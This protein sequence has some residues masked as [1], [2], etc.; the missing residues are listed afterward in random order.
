MDRG[1]NQDNN[2]DN[3]NFIVLND[4]FKNTVHHW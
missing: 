1:S 4:F 3:N 2:Q